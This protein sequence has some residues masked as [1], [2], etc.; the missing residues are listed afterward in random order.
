MRLLKG[1]PE[2]VKYILFVGNTDI[3]CKDCV[4]L[5]KENINKIK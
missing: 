5:Q 3:I 2:D 4:L 1:I